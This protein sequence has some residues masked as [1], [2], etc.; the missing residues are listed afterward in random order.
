MRGSLP[1]LPQHT[2]M[3]W[4]SAKKGTETDLPYLTLPLFIDVV[5]AGR[6]SV[7]TFSLMPGFLVACSFLTSYTWNKKLDNNQ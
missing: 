7:S 4:C 5:F 2:L 6:N 3:A 1:P